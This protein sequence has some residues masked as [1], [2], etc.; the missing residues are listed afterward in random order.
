M[1]TIELYLRGLSDKPQKPLTTMEMY[2]QGVKIE[3]PKPR[4][5]IECY[6]AGVA[7]DEWQ[8][9]DHPRDDDGKFSKVR[10]KNAKS[11]AKNAGKCKI[12]RRRR[13]VRLSEKE[14]AEVQSAFMTDVTK[15]QRKQ[16]VLKKYIGNYIYTGILRED[17]TRD[18]VKRIK[19]K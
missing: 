2:L 10:G 3:P 7:C 12:K 8:E 6:L 1:D 4:T 17:G 5:V 13:I 15:E 18:I 19:I 9:E 16:S 14:F 11:V